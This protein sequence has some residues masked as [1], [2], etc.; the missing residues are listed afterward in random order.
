MASQQSTF[1]NETFPW[2]SGTRP[3]QRSSRS[4]SSNGRISPTSVSSGSRIFCHGL[5]LLFLLTFIGLYCLGNQ[6]HPDLNGDPSHH[7]AVPV[8]DSSYANS[9]IIVE[10]QSAPS[11][12]HSLSNTKT[13]DQSSPHILAPH[14]TMVTPSKKDDEMF[15]NRTTPLHQEKLL[16][17]RFHWTNLTPHMDL[18]RRMVAHQSNCE[19][20]LGTFLYRNR[21]GLGSDLH[22]WGQALCNGLAH[23]MRLRTVGNWTW[24][25][26]EHCGGKEH[27]PMLCYFQHAELNCPGDIQAAIEQPGFDPE[28]SLSRANGIVVKACE[29]RYAVLRATTKKLFIF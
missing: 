12:A 22:I 1:L 11:N 6:Y 15:E 25:D 26:E 20:P 21:F 14:A 18:T 4:I 9:D 23:N 7:V 24:M 28:S 27:S 8:V 19:A 5:R 2:R 16:S 13:V 17:L 29:H 3:A 10:Y